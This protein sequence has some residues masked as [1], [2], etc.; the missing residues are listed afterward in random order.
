[1]AF[2]NESFVLQGCIRRLQ[3]GV[4]LTVIFLYVEVLVSVSLIHQIISQDKW[5]VV[6]SCKR[7]S[8]IADKR[9]RLGA[10]GALTIL[11]KEWFDLEDY[12]TTNVGS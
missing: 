1:M 7:F 5:E 10:Q 9:A 2:K 6:E 4:S 8:H 12:G 11:S 3:W